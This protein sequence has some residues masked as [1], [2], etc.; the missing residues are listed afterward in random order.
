MKDLGKYLKNTRISNG[1]SIEEAA[2]DLELSTSQ[3]ENIENGNTR[4]FNDIYNLRLLVKNY[5]KYLGL[6]Y[7]KVIDEF[8]DFLF[9]HTSK[10]SLDDILEAQ[11]NNKDEKSKKVSSPYTNIPNKKISIWPVL[12]F[13]VLLFIIVVVIYLIFSFINKAP[14]R[15]SELKGDCRKDVLYE[16]TY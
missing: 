4:A 13:F 8:N 15:N 7:E 1:V 12:S 11:K 14:I 3:I 2:E 9:E 6:D 16:F 5:A 10:I